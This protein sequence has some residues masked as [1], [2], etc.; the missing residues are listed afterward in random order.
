MY[1]CDD[2]FYVSTYWVTEY[3]DIQLNIIPGV[4]VKVFLKEISARIHRMSKAEYP[5][6]CG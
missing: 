5:S 1:N 3:P 2:E 6:Q 4:S